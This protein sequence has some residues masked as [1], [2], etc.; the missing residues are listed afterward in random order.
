MI[1]DVI[2]TPQFRHVFSVLLGIGIVVVIFRPY[3]KDGDCGIWKAPPIN[4]VHDSVYKIGEKCY[5]FKEV[6]KECKQG[7]KYIEAFRGEFSC[8]QRRQ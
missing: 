6:D 4:Q 2:R 5:E 7:E 3:C 8:R 1:A